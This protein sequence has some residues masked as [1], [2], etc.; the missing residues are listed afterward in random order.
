MSPLTFPPSEEGFALHLR[1]LDATDLLASND[2]CERY[3]EPLSNCLATRFPSAHPDDRFT[4]AE[5]ALMTY[6][7]NPQKYDPA[8]LDLGKFLRMVALRDL[9]NLSRKEA[10]HQRKRQVDF[11]VE[12]S[13]LVGNS[14]QEPLTVLLRREEQADASRIVEAVRAECSEP[15]RAG[16]ALLIDGERASIRYATAL[17]VE[18]L[19]EKEMRH[20]VKKF[21]DRLEKRIGRK[22][23]AND[24]PTREDG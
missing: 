1:L 8:K 3:L 9:S 2:I 22:G 6:F 24:D 11:R 7:E 18:H 21:K 16:L 5:D 20:E 19:P 13:R 10:R 15:E 17:G 14:L 4:A 23:E 12:E